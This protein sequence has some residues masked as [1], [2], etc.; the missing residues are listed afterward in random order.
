MERAELRELFPWPELMLVAI[1][2]ILILGLMVRSSTSSCHQWKQQL[3]Q[4][5]GAF[6][7]SAGAE[8]HPLAEPERG[9]AEERAAL[10][11][12]ARRLLDQ[13]PFGCL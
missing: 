3:N 1:G 11:D 12:A 5:N 10:R 6:M 8:E 13:R 4:V 9:A 7:A 2:L